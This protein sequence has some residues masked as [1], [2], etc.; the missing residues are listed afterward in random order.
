MINSA[1][2]AS[3]VISKECKSVV[4]QYGQNILDLLMAQVMTAL[5]YVRNPVV[6]CLW[7]IHWITLI[8]SSGFMVLVRQIIYFY[9]PMNVCDWFLFSLL[10]WQVHPKKVCSQIG[11]CTFDGTRVVR[12]VLNDILVLRMLLFIC[13]LFACYYHFTSGYSFSIIF[14]CYCHLNLSWFKRCNI[15]GYS[16]SILTRGWLLGPCL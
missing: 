11:L 7:N 6:R 4:Q 2:G 10:S 12:L 16:L 3:G 14:P 15:Y 1:I 9:G 5:F 13:L 8:C